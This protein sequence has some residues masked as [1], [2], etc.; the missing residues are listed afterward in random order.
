M[1]DNIM[2]VMNDMDMNLLFIVVAI[3]FLVSAIYGLA[4]GAVRVLVSLIATALTLAMVYFGSPYVTDFIYDHTPIDN[5]IQEQCTSI[6]L[7]AIVG[8]TSDGSVGALSEDSVRA[9]L[10][11]AGI[12]EADLEA[13]GITIED[14]VEGKVTGEDLASF[15]ISEG[16]LAGHRT[17]E[18]KIDYNEILEAQDIPREVQIKAIE[19]AKIPDVF[20]NLLLANNNSEVYSELGVTSFAGY[21]SAYLTKLVLDMVVFIVLFVFISIVIRAIVFAMDFVAD[22]PGLGTINHVT[23]LAL[24]I[25]SALIMVDVLF[26]VLTMLNFLGI[27]FKLL[28]MVFE[29]P[30]LKILYENNYIMKVA[31]IFR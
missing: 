9:M 28:D 26:L 8:D 29:N 7:K 31:T 24:G 16:V 20:K 3:T 18:E 23:G 21:I 14:I 5:V 30:L 1:L 2:T 22:L 12:S 15:G 6:I 19:T 17:E 11:G 10:N 4:K 13:V 25:I 27:D